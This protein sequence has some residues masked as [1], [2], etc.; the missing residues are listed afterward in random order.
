MGCQCPQGYR[1]CGGICW[2]VNRLCCQ[3]VRCP[4]N[5]TDCCLGCVDFWTLPGAETAWV[6][7]RQQNPNQK[8]ADCPGGTF[9][10]NPTLVTMRD[11]Q[12]QII[13]CCPPG[14]TGLSAN[15]RCAGCPL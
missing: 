10:C 13:G 2:P 11:P 5:S 12:G 8:L 15:G 6:R 9:S 4:P 1:L 14:C 3:D 7:W